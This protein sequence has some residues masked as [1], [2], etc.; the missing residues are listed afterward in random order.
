MTKVELVL[1][2]EQLTQKHPMNLFLLVE[3]RKTKFDCFK[4][5]Q[6]GTDVL[7]R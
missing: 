1:S 4:N 2:M 6:I 5:Q 3:H 7:L